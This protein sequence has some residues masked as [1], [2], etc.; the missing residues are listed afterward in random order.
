MTSPRTGWNDLPAELQI[1]VFKLLFSDY[2]R[3]VN[4]KH[5]VIDAPTPARRVRFP[6]PGDAEQGLEVDLRYPADFMMLFTSRNF[7]DQA[8][9]VFAA[10]APIELIYA[11]AVS[12]NWKGNEPKDVVACAVNRL[13]KL[14]T[15]LIINECNYHQID[16]RA[17]Q[18]AK[19][20]QSLDLYTDVFLPWIKL[21]S[22]PVNL[23]PGGPKHEHRQVY[24][25]LRGNADMSK[26]VFTQGG[27]ILRT[28]RARFG[29]GHISETEKPT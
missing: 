12:S 15:R 18:L 11:E 22:A 28:L 13:L 9:P 25:I 7:F 10:N 19:N 17:I 3:T 24:L 2:N 14:T 26:K 29:N 5:P 21:P 27:W 1:L 6:M 4:D 23:Y 20:V 16:R 8:Y